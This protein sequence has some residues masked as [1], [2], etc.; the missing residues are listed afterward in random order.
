MKRLYENSYKRVE[1]FMNEVD[2]LSRLRHQS[3][4]TLYGCTSSNSRELLLVYEYV[5]NG[6]VADHLHGSRAGERALTWSL[7]LNIA[8]EAAD[9]LAYLHAV[10]PQ[11]IHRDVK[12]TN[13]LLDNS[14]HV[15]VG[16]FGMSRLFPLDV[17]HVSTAP[18]GT[19]G[20]VDPEYYQCYQLTDKSDVYS[21]GVVLVELISSKPAVDINRSR[22]EVN[23]ASFAI[24]KIQSNELD[25][26][27]DP[28]I[29]H[30]SDSEMKKMIAQMAELAFR[31]LRL[32]RDMRPPMKE[33][34]EVLRGIR[35]GAN[36]V[37]NVGKG[38]LA[39]EDA[40][41]LR[42]NPPY[43][44]DSVTDRWMSKSTTPNNSA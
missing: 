18:Q 28:E 8:I 35:D 43:S 7:R 3:L 25:Q 31:C 10:E 32:E 15:K 33:V 26:L 37:E 13:I 24:S 11:I 40:Y 2:I 29:G 17:T 20:Y 19:P 21:F 6:T 1:Q 30:H 27:V 34:L 22:Y 44:P 9:A 38:A 12:T 5:S 16:D 23:L 42:K 36:N 4:V 41:L 39:Q 14:F